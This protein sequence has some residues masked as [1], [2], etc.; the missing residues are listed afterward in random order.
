MEDNELIDLYFQRSE[1]AIAITEQKY[2]KLCFGVAKHILTDDRDVEECVTDAYMHV[3]NAIPPERPEKF[4]AFIARITRNLAL[5]KYAFNHAERRDS[6]LTSAFDELEDFLKSPVDAQQEVEDNEF[7][8]FINRFLGNLK[9]EARV[10]FV[11]RYFYG[12]SVAEICE[13]TDFGEEK[14][15]SSLFRTRKLLKT[16][17]A[18]QGIDF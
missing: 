5:D 15:K 11:K 10:I 13:D 3:W 12:E 2:G 8:E 1:N 14:V 9:E 4:G 17:L 6:S 18:N 7:R 16:A